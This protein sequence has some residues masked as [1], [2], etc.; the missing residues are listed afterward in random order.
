M[1]LFLKPTPASSTEWCLMQRHAPKLLEVL[2]ISFVVL[3]VGT[4][5]FYAGRIIWSN[6][7]VA[8]MI[9]SL[10]AAGEPVNLADLASK[11]IPPEDDAA[12]Y[13][14]RATS[15]NE[16]IRKD[17]E[18]TYDGLPEAE[19][20]AFDAGHPSP[21]MVSAIR[22]A[23]NAHP[24]SLTLLAHAAQCSGYSPQSNVSADTQAFTETLF[25]NMDTIRGAIR[26]LDYRVQLSL[27]DGRP[28]E[29][30]SACLD[31]LRLARHF[32]REPT[33]N[34]YFLSLAARGMAIRS[35]NRI[36]R[37]GPLSDAEYDAL[38]AELARHNLVNAYQQALRTERAFGL[39]S[40]GEQPS[41]LL[42]KPDQ[43][44]YLD[45]IEA[46]LPAMSTP[47]ASSSSHAQSSA[48]LGR[49]GPLTKLVAPATQAMQDATARTLAEMRCLRVLNELMRHEQHADTSEPEIADL[50]LPAD[51]T[52]DPFNG[53]S[54]R[55]KK[56]AHGWLVY[57]VGRD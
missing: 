57:T 14:R 26:V 56:L 47:L 13:L 10:R 54:L 17:V 21:A 11:P 39:E 9:A 22:T 24:D 36:L 44:D 42:H 29:A 1:H 33:L 52:V 4:I 5:L 7:R 50:G 3:L 19:Q 23:L 46:E 20:Q 35:A 45:L 37:A 48:I 41:P 51:V 34:N 43:R 6:V 31:M 25:D 18:V 2:A 38:A 27:A 49:A 15:G 53:N 8:Q 40:F 12:T 16:A 30:L 32:D 55:V 28:Q